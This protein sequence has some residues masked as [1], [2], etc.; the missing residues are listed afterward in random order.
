M[1][2]ARSTAQRA[3]ATRA[4]AC[5]LGIAQAAT[6]ALHCARGPG[7]SQFV[8][9][10]EFETASYSLQP[11]F[12]TEFSRPHFG[13]R[14]LPARERL[15]NLEPKFEGD[16]V[17]QTKVQGPRGALLPGAVGPAPQK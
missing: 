3:A 2:H 13:S 17:G 4:E 15:S 8:K 7:R 16:N 5:R 9:R 10:R 12:M 14:A 11:G 1:E 6:L